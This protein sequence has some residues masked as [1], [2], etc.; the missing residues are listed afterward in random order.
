MMVSKIITNMVMIFIIA[1][2]S[3][4][5]AGYD[6]DSCNDKNDK[7]KLF[8]KYLHLG[9][10]PPVVHRPFENNSVLDNRP[11]LLIP[12]ATSKACLK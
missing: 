4:D 9:R 7:F 8:Y 6:N 10:F 5:K 2:L 3:L 11:S 12:P 1:A